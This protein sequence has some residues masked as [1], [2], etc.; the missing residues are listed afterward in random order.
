M[1]PKDDGAAKTWT[2]DK[3]RDFL[4]EI[5]MRS[6]VTPNAAIYDELVKKWYV[7]RCPSRCPSTTTDKT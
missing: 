6:N 1:P 5:I 3:E 4:F 2:A 7:S